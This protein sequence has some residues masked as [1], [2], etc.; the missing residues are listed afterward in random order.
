MKQQYALLP[1]N[2][3]RLG[4]KEILVNEI[5]DLLVTPEGTVQK[6]TDRAIDDAELYKT[7]AANWRPWQED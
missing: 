1:F 6:I 5:G 3:L 2:F 4:N 7:L